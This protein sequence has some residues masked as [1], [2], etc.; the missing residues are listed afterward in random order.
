MLLKT[1]THHPK[2]N[3]NKNICKKSNALNM[4]RHVQNSSPLR[5]KSDVGVGLQIEKKRRAVVLNVSNGATVFWVQ[6]HFNWAWGKTSHLISRP[7]ES[8]I[9]QPKNTRTSLIFTVLTTCC[10]TI[11]FPICTNILP[12]HVNHR[13]LLIW[14]IIRAWRM[15]LLP[16]WA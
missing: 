14:Q 13:Q 6:N 11:L 10:L 3:P 9:K 15:V 4:H 16:N 12:L 5:K 7:W 1:T 2:K 8:A